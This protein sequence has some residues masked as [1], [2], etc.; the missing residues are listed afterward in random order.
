MSKYNIGLSGNGKQVYANL[1]KQPLA[2]SIARNPGL[3]SLVATAINSLDLSSQ[4]LT[5]SC[6]MGQNVGYSEVLET[7]DKDS[8]FYA[9]TS[10]LPEYTRFVKL[11]A[12]EKSSVITLQLHADE[13]GGYQ[14]VN[15][16]IGI[17]YPPAPNTK[18]EAPQSKEYWRN[19]A[20]VFNGQSI[21]TNS[22]TKVCPY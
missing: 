16:W 1:T 22:V 14:L 8:I 15:V 20:V 11:R 17:D 4:M 13:T 18:I 2:A 3:L 9:Q 5:V 6:D 19:H 21:L 12:A 10:K 7:G